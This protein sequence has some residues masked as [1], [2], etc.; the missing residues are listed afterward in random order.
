MFGALPVSSDAGGALLS[1]VYGSPEPSFIFE[2]KVSNCAGF[3]VFRVRS[4]RVLGLRG[5]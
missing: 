2:P 3:G 5:F 1:G 4:F